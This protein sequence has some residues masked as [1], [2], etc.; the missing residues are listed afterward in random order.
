MGLILKCLGN[1]S[2]HDTALTCLSTLYGP[3]NQA[4]SFLL[5]VGF[6]RS[7]VDSH[8]LLP[9]LNVGASRLFLS[10]YYL[11]RLTLVVM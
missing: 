9:G 8:T 6:L 10:P 11:C 1:S 7:Q 2:L 5:L 4:D 3:M